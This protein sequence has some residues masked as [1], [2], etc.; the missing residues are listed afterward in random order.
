VNAKQVNRRLIILS[1]LVL[2]VSACKDVR[3]A[4]NG[5]INDVEKFLS[6]IVL[7]KTSMN[8]YYGSCS[9]GPGLCNPLILEKF[10]DLTDKEMIFYYRF[11]GNMCSSSED[12]LRSWKTID[13]SSLFEKNR[14]TS[15]S[16]AFDW[17]NRRFDIADRT[18]SF[19]LM[20]S[21]LSLLQSVNV[22]CSSNS[23]RIRLLFPQ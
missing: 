19:N 21:H 11:K 6:R 16:D 2:I 3:Y 12:A 7:S 13:I 10:E 18:G 8:L 20:K 5:P 9:E 15:G 14:P 23:L 4:R 1:G 22:D 17:D